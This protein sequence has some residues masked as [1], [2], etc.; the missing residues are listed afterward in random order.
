MDSFIF[1][2]PLFSFRKVYI[3]F[4][5]KSVRLPSVTFLVNVSFPKLLEVAISKVCSIIGHMM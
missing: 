1:L 3:N 5:A 2:C 4:V